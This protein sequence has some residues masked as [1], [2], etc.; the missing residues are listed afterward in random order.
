MTSANG[1]DTEARAQRRCNGGNAKQSAERQGD[2]LGCGRS[3]LRQ[4]D[5]LLQ[6]NS[7]EVMGRDP[8][9]RMIF[10]YSDDPPRSPKAPTSHTGFSYRPPRQPGTDHLTFTQRPLIMMKMTKRQK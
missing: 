2:I 10:F 1:N 8:K 6:R 9:M 3:V 5:P 7:S 4:R